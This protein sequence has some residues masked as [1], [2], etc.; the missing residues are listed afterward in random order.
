MT[1]SL[2]ALL[3]C[4]GSG[5]GFAAFDAARKWAT[6]ALSPEPLLILILAGHLPVFLLWLGIEGVV[7]PTAGYVLPGLLALGVGIASNLMFLKSIAEAP[8][9]ETVPLL[10][11]T[12]ALAAVGALVTLQEGLRLPQIA[13]I[14][15]VFLGV[16]VLYRGEGK[17]LFSAFGALATR[18]GARLMAGVAVL[19]SILPVLDKLCVQASSIAVHAVIQLS[20]IILALLIWREWKSQTGSEQPPLIPE[21][22]GWLAIGIAGFSGALAL[23]FQLWALT[24]APVALVETLKRVIGQTAA[25]ISG[26]LFFNEPWTAQKA[27]AISL[28]GFGVPLVL[29]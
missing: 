12:P 5:L 15:L 22:R 20:G 6:A 2:V 3:I 19:W 4:L 13:G 27:L 28:M 21:G 9:S 18:R 7:P 26:G 1:I 11:L 29:L 24:L 14:A 17:S 23:G 8:I 16:L 25:V 10:S